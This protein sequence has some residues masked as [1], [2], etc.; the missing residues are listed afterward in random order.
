MNKA[1][2]L[3]RDGIINIDKA[4]VVKIEDFEFSPHIFE[5]LAYLQHLDY[6]LIIVTNQ[7]GIGRGYYS[8]KDFETLT[9]WMV[10]QCAQNGIMIEAV[11]HCPHTP[12]DHCDCRKPRPK[13]LEDAMKDYDIDP[14]NSWMIGDKASDIE[15]GMNAGISQTI[16]VN[17][18]RCDK[19]KYNAK[20]IFDIISIIKE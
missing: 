1:I 2:F 19:A 8:E 12:E 18:T 6:K 15:A 16:F 20:T 11:Y 4:Y 7:S 17:N 9:K 10:K 3:D 14:Q 5:V 13:M